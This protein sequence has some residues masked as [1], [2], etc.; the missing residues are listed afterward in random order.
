MIAS[1]EDVLL[2]RDSKIKRICREG[3]CLGA[4]FSSLYWAMMK[5]LLGGDTS[6][7]SDLLSTMPE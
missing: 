4:W 1:R 7:A 3:S 6:P 2:T 5:V